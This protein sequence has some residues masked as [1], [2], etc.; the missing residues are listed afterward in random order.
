MARP[1]AARRLTADCWQR[2]RP[3]PPTGRRN[4][5]CS[6]STVTPSAIRLRNRDGT[7]TPTTR[8]ASRPAVP[9]PGPGRGCPGGSCPCHVLPVLPGSRSRAQDATACPTTYSGLRARSTPFEVPPHRGTLVLDQSTLVG[10]IQ[11]RSAAIAQPPVFGRHTARLTESVAPLVFDP[12]H[13]NSPSH[14]ARRIECPCGVPEAP[15]SIPA[16][17]ARRVRRLALLPPPDQ[18]GDRPGGVTVTGLRRPGPSRRSGRSAG[19]RARGGCAG[20]T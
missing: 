16:Q 6:G 3:T 17:L 5:A 4:C 8:D 9:W 15:R 1:P 10:E 11:D 7:G 20:W 2:L 13:H 14:A 18:R 19:N 12:L